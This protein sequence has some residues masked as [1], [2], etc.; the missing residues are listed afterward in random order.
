MKV[1]LFNNTINK[2]VKTI[3]RNEVTVSKQW[4]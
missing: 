2:I 1:I 4:D 3:N